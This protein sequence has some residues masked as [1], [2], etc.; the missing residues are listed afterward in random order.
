MG[1]HVVIPEKQFTK[2]RGI[3]LGNAGEIQND[4]V[5]THFYCSQDPP[6]DS[7]GGGKIKL[8]S[9][10][11]DFCV[12]LLM[13]RI[14]KHRTYLPVMKGMYVLVNPFLPWGTIHQKE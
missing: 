8:T 10:G 12:V 13:F 11:K 1:S 6:L 9:K 7:C 5:A 14:L 4:V 3:N 2:A